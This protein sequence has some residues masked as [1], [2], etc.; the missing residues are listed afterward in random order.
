MTRWTAGSLT[1]AIALAAA[2]CGYVQV[3]PAGVPFAEDG[4][5]GEQLRYFARCLSCEVTFQTP[6]G[7]DSESVE[8]SWGRSFRL[9]DVMGAMLSVC[10]ADRDT[11]LFGEISIGGRTVTTDE[12]G[13]ATAS[14]RSCVTLSTS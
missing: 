12:I 1:A 9:D 11:H 14:T 2:G 6:D 7:I 8:G 3:R 5:G 10:R 13:W 4:S